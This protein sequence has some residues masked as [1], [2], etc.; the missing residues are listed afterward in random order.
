MTA[1]PDIQPNKISNAEDNIQLKAF[2]LRQKI[3]NIFQI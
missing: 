2:T 1:T 3:M